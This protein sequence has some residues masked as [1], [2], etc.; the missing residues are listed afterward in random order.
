[1]SFLEFTFLPS[2]VA[3]MPAREAGIIDQKVPPLGAY[4]KKEMKLCVKC[5]EFYV[6]ARVAHCVTFSATSTFP[7]NNY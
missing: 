6:Y 7:E 4:V 3:Q 2:G 1:V 5:S